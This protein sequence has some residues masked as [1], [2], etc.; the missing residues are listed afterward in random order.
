MLMAAS[1]AEAYLLRVGDAWLKVDDG[2]KLHN[3][4]KFL[5]P[6]PAVPSQHR[7]RAPCLSEVGRLGMEL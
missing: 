5:P 6:A 2:K 4:E 7:Y 3:R 1:R